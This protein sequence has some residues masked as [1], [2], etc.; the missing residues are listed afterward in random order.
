MK[1]VS[2][3]GEGGSTGEP[4]RFWLDRPR[5]AIPLTIAGKRPMVVSRVTQSVG[6]QEARR[7]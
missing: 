6:E 5:D 4:T 2:S 1:G 3:R 7:T